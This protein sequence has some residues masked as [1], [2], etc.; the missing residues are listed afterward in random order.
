MTDEHSVVTA[1]TAV[2]DLDVLVNNVEIS[3]A[4]QPRSEADLATLRRVYE[5]NVSAWLP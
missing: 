3:D 2:P 5:T 4:G 1:A